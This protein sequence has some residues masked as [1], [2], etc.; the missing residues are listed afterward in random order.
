M[1]HTTTHYNIPLPLGIALHKMYE[2][3]VVLRHLILQIDWLKNVSIAKDWRN[4]LTSICNQNISQYQSHG[5]VNSSENI[6]PDAWLGQD[7]IGQAWLSKVTLHQITLGLFNLGQGW[8]GLELS[9]PQVLL[10]YS[11]RCSKR[12]IRVLQQFWLVKFKADNVDGQGMYS[13]CDAKTH[14]NDLFIR[15][16]WGLPPRFIS[17]IAVSQ[18]EPN[19]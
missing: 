19:A 10:S 14:K 4:W 16:K 18:I 3:Y 8:F 13:G 1:L 2:Q 11:V 9:L 6:A 5:Q 17:P 12:E 15:L 7:G